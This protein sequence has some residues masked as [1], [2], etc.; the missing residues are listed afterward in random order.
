MLK[1]AALFLLFDFV[2][3]SDPGGMSR[4]M[5]SQMEL[6][7]DPNPGLR[8]PEPVPAPEPAPL[9]QPSPLPSPEP[10]PRP[11]GAEETSAEGLHLS[12]KRPGRMIRHQGSE[13]RGVREARLAQLTGVTD[14]LVI[15]RFDRADTDRNGK[16]SWGELRRFQAEVYRDFRYEN[17]ARALR[18]REFFVA[19]GGD[20]EDFAIFSAAMLTYWGWEAYVASLSTNPNDAHA[21]VFVRVDQPPSW[22]SYY[23]VTA[24]PEDPRFETSGIF[25]PVDYDI[26]GGLSN[27]VTPGSKVTDIV[28]PREWYGLAI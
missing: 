20:C 22:A 23:E 10:R 14:E 11:A 27:A 4:G 9:P 6:L 21:V 28:V 7:I 18:P 26:V 24:G 3:S 12:A 17:N 2:I 5:L 13:E 8:P 16:L 25:V 1:A 19:G 15:S